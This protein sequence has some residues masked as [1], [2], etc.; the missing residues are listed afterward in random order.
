MDVYSQAFNFS[1]Y[2]N[3]A[4]DVR[5]GQYNVRINLMTLC[6][7]GPLEASREIAL[8][9]SMLSTQSS[10]YGPGW[11]LSNTEFDSARL[12]LTLL[13]GEQ[14]KAE[15]MPIVGGTL[16]LK[17]R[18]LQDL[19]VSRPDAKTLHVIYKD[20]TV[21][22][23]Q[24]TSGSTL[25]RIVAIEFEN[26]ERLKWEYTPGG[27]LER[28]VGNDQEVLLLLTYS[29]GRLA[30][31]D[32]Q[33]DGGRYARIRLTYSS[34]R[35]TAVT[36]PYDRE[37]PLQSAGYVFGYT[38]AFSNGLFGIAH[39]KSPMGGEEII[40]YV[41]RGHQYGN[42]QYIPRVFSW[43]QTPASGQL[44]ITRTY[45]YSP[46]NNFTGFPYSGGFREGEDN[47]YLTIGD[48]RYWTEEQ[49]IDP[50]NDTALYST[51]STFNKF[52][53]LT[54][55]KVLREGALATTFIT[56]NTKPGLFPEQPANLQLPNTI[57]KRYELLARSTSREEEQ[58]IETDDYG[59]ELSR[60]EASGVRTEY[61]YYPINGESGKCPADPHGLFQRYIKHERLIPAGGTPTARL[62]EYSHTRVPPTG[63]KY[64]VLQQSSAQANGF[65]QQQTYY[66]TP[67]VL[68]GRLK[69]TTS[70]IDGQS[71]VSYFTYTVTGD[72]LSETRRLQGRE[73]Q[74][75]ESVRKLSLVNRRLLSM[76]RDGDSTLTLAFDV[77][78]RLLSETVSAGKPQQAQ[79]KYA[80][81]FATPTK[82]AH[83]VTTDAQNNQV[84][85]YFD[86][87]GRKVSE[88]QLIN[89]SQERAIG[90]CRY[91]AQGR[92]VEKVSIDYLTDGPRWLKS[93]FTYNRW[94]N[95][96][97]VAH[98]DASVT[99]DEYDPLLNLKIE[100]VEGGERLRTWFNDHGQPIKV[101][102]LDTADNSVDVQS[103][104]YDGLGRCLSLLDISKN[105]TEFTYDAYGRCL[106]TLQKPA[107]GTPQRLRHNDYVLGTSSE[108]VGALTVDGKCLGA[109]TYDSLGRMTSQTHGMGQATTWEYEA[110]WM[111]PVAVLSPRGARQH[112][113]YDKELDVPTRIEM[114]GLPVSTYGHDL[115]AG[116]LTRSE[117]NGLVH[118]FFLDGNGH[119]EK[120]I[121]SAAGTSLTTRYDYS[122]G[123]RVLHQT[124]AN[125]QSSEFEY[126]AEGR[127]SKMTTGS[128]VVEQSY[129]NFGRPQNLTA[130]YDT[131]RI[132]TKVSYDALGREAERRF[133]Q[134]GTLLQVM[135]SSYHVN[136]ML[137]TRFLRDANS[138]VVIGETFTYDAYLRLKTYRCEGSEHPRDQMGRGIVGQE[139]SF[140]SLNNITR[141]VTAFAD[142]TQDI[143][144]R[145]FTAADPTQLTR[146][147]HTLPAQDVTLTYDAAG[148]LLV[149]PSGQAYTYNAFEQLTGVQVDGLQYNYQYDAESRQVLASRGSEPPVMLAYAGERLETLVEGDKK[150]R[151][152][153]GEDQVIA[154]SG[155]VD[156]PQL[157]VSDASGSV[158]GLSAPGQ[159][160]V[161]RHYTPYGEVKLALDDG[162][163]RSMADLQL[164]A[165]NG[166][167][168][169]AATNLYIQGN[170][171]RAYDPALMM[172]LQR[173]PLS[174]FDEGGINSYAYCACNPINLMD[175]SGLWPNWLKWVLT[176]VGLAFSA[177]VLGFATPGVI[178][179]AAAYTAAASVAATAG[180]A[181]AAAAASTATMLLASKVALTVSSALGVIGGTLGI[182][183]LGVAEV[184]RQKGW[185]RSHHIQN[186][187]WASFGFSIM[188]WVVSAAGAYT[189]ASLAYNAAVKAGTA[190]DFVGYSSF[191]DTPVGSGILAAGKRTV[192]LSYKFTD[193]KGI[194]T[195]SKAFGVSRFA[196]R[197]T[198]FGRAIEARSKSAPPQSVPESDHADASAPAQPQR[199]ATGSRLFD[200]TSSITDYYQSFRDEATRIR[201]PLAPF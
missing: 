83:L 79:R 80:Y 1:S 11:W 199:Q 101:E 69:S 135:T 148:N 191:F 71:L 90:T 74:W 58:Q 201:Q 6:P 13:T 12:R 35:L 40:R 176:G 91:D 26:G 158:R 173:D 153:N 189:S 156:G 82:A 185:D 140:D 29:S 147:T 146:L 63:D 112:L 50:G 18:K 134:G 47:L 160:H 85:T 64:F 121:Q 164:P 182:A 72:T 141:V 39:V 197:T 130:S 41:E 10:V 116:T 103:R 76:T 66:D 67:G 46:G 9:F 142:G 119:P 65:S 190:K 123:G 111:E 159:P 132:V 200:M 178:A 24:Q 55:E 165:L 127:F 4:V 154:R 114:S 166:Q 37:G 17:D 155:G 175:P 14:F 169:D 128:M 44:P 62:T 68:A 198:N 97:R 139:F 100:G 34:G 15:S 25:Y 5:T 43:V 88:F 122:P 125:G 126:D 195:F 152:F 194:T 115:V 149:G 184:D 143:C 108:M 174:P 31:V 151:Y 70:T 163:V 77:T 42:G 75:L 187:G 193:E 167:R 138:R 113:V 106:T 81:H 179:A 59:N 170:G 21:E 124:A 186:L 52:H 133:E 36:A 61:S 92:I 84:I 57:I 89:A 131:T 56:Y 94:G 53:L 33:V 196:L 104:T 120:E 96:S 168:L 38:P 28:I 118:E 54:E 16:V 136:S 137:A 49:Y 181:A 177:V 86:G 32:S 48:Y 19:V 3:G 60:T 157:H 171:M 8:S 150:I 188:S 161:R 145:F 129:D 109:R 78:G 105:L 22:V 73:G 27:S 107:D 180:T 192:G 110:G 93:T 102:R 87:M 45:T 99:I 7:R 183:G 172:F 20:G 51:R 95:A 23:L 144:E 2:L 98:A 162:K 30:M 117:T